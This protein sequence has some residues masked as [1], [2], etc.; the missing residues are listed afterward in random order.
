LIHKL[1]GFLNSKKGGEMKKPGICLLLLA[2]IA[3]TV[4]S[5]TTVNICGFVRDPGGKPLTNTLVRLS[6]TKPNDSLGNE[7]FYTTTDSIGFYHLGSGNCQTNVIQESSRPQGNVFSHPILVGSELLFSVPQDNAWVRISMFDMT[8]RLIKDLVNARKADGSYSVAINTRGVSSQF[9]VVRVS[10]NG[11]STV[12]KLQ[13]H[14]R[15]AAV[16]AQN[17]LEFH[18]SLKKLAA[19][20]D[21]IH[22]T[23]PGYSFGVTPIGVTTGQYDFV[24]TKTNTWNG[25]TAAFWGDTAK[26]AADAKAAGHFI[27]ELINRTNGQVP[28]SLIYWA[29]GDGGT[30]VRWIDQKVITPSTSG[31]LYIMAGYNAATSKPFRPNSQ[32][33]DWEEHNTGAA[34]YNGNLTRVDYYGMPLAMRLHGTDGSKDQVRG[35]I[36][37]M[38]FQG[39]EAIF[40]E[41]LNEVPKDWDTCATYGRPA[42]IYMPCNVPAFQTASGSM[43]HYWDGYQ[44]QCGVTAGSCVGIN[45]NRISSGLFRHVLELPDAQKKDWN[46][47]YKKAPCSF[48]AYWVHRRAFQHLEYAFP[49]DD[50]NEWSSFIHSGSAQWMAIAVGY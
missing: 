27:F 12:F 8:G 18:A 26:F 28:D 19:I 48:F 1:L 40:D 33:W 24:L 17:A 38:F 45:D 13:P 50:Y 34:S 5:Q 10:I 32:V 11:V 22:A 25:D 2:V 14:S 29:N 42:K 43:G 36:Y 31:R 20:V 16:A 46:Y 41:Y 7:P 15:G 4:F 23:E 39:R 30:P 47:Q 44:K 3:G 6:V 37:P 21:T 49:Y 35:N 9:Y